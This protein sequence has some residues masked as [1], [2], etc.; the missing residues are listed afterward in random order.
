MNELHILQ[1]QPGFARDGTLLDADS[2]TDGEWVRFFKGRPKKIGGYRAMTRTADGPVRSLL[3]DS[4]GGVNSLHSFSQWEVRRLEFD[5]NGS[6]GSLEDRT[7]G[8]Y[9][10]DPRNTWSHAIMTSSTGGS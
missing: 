9:I 8:S 6:G 1:S 3:V 10:I 2:Y 4:R 5:D 7:P